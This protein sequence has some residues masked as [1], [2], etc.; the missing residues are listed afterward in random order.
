MGPGTIFYKSVRAKWGLAPF[1]MGPGT[2]FYKSAPT[3]YGLGLY[4]WLVEIFPVFLLC[5]K[6]WNQFSQGDG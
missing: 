5:L 2:I 1:S 4:L 6:N 3:E